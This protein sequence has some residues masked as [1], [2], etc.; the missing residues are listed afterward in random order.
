[1][2][3]KDINKYNIADTNDISKKPDIRK[4]PKEKPNEIINFYDIV[5]KKYLD[6]VENPNYNLHHIDLPFRMCV[7]APSGSGKT[8]FV[9]N[10]I[11]VMSVG[12][13]TFADITIVT[14][15]KDE[16][17]YNWLSGQNDNI[18]ILEGM[19]N[20]PKLDDYDKK[21]NHLLI[22]DD[23][24]L[25]KNLTPVC[26]YYIRARKKN[27]SLLFLSQSYVDI[28]KIIRKNSC[29]LVLLNLGGS[30]REQDYILREWSGELERDELRLIY[31]DATE[32][33][34]NPLIIKGGKC[35]SNEK[36]RKGFIG[37]YNLNEFFKD[38]IID[39]KPKRNKSKIVNDY[40]DSSESESDS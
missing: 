22:W 27:V 9:L 17:L 19:T 20:N 15:N 13:G 39:K 10:L 28:P 14:R 16:P 23:L 38:K 35:K 6:D 34:M 24:V 1:M 11:R 4:K 40:I 32:K 18:R 25:S 29:Y 31:D 26:E 5:P 8:N 37:F 30:K 21:Y 12:K 36:Y 7:V 2:N 3:Y 33:H